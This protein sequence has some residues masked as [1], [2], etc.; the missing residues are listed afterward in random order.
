MID[1]YYPDDLLTQINS[2]A[3]EKSCC[4]A[5]RKQQEAFGSMRMQKKKKKAEY[6]Y[7][8]QKKNK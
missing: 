6:I 2:L 7:F 1:A 3:Q 5:Y 4:I 8:K